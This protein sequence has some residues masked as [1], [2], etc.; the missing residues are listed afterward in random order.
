MVIIS[1]EGDWGN[2]FRK[3][4]K[5]VC[6]VHATF[7]FFKIIFEKNEKFRFEKDGYLLYYFNTSLFNIQLFSNIP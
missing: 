6:N 7:H 1:R 2:K 4:E 5:Y 3:V